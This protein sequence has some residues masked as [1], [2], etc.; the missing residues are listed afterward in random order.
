MTN[1]QNKTGESRASRVNYGKQCKHTEGGE[2]CELCDNH[3]GEHRLPVGVGPQRMTQFK[4]TLQAIDKVAAVKRPTRNV[5]IEGN[6]LTYGRTWQHRMTIT[7]NID[8][9]C[10]HVSIKC[11]QPEM[12]IDPV[13]MR[14]IAK[15]LTAT[16]D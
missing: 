16:A 2:R 1:E 5:R 12:F 14:A 15:F 9:G 10:G 7:N 3:P 8:R 11:D 13:D 4:R 6:V